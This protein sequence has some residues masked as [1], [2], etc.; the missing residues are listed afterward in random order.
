[1][2][3]PINKSRII[4]LASLFSVFILSI[5]SFFALRPVMRAKK[6][7]QLLGATQVGQTSTAEFRKMAKSYGVS[8][9]ESSD[10]FD[11]SQQNR[12]W[13][14]LHL[15]P[16]TVMLMNARTTGGVVS[17]IT[18]HAWVGGSGEFAKINIDEFDSHN[19]SCG[20]VPICVQRTS[21]TMT[22]YVFFVPTT[23]QDQRQRLLSLNTWCLAKLWG[24]K[25]SR[26]FFPVAWDSQYSA[27]VGG[28]VR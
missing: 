21:S 20:D 3:N 22:T 6:A 2:R 8:L 18:A 9:E 26:E 5:L 27:T 16:P 10:A 23:P 25:S 7:L 4:A 19:T 1:M 14:Y 24:C 17:G 12:V 13:Q 28:S 11:L 15:A